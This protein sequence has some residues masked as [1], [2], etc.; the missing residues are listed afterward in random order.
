MSDGME[1]GRITITHN[2]DPHGRDVT[3]CE[4]ADPDGDPLP[5]VQSLGLLRLAEDT[6]IRQAMGETDA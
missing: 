3:W 2:I 4:A 1:I 5:L 6:L